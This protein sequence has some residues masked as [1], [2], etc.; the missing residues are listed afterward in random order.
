MDSLRKVKTTRDG[1]KDGGK[2]SKDVNPLYRKKK[3]NLQSNGALPAYQG[4]WAG[5][6]SDCV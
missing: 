3:T 2:F 6:A 5:A 4:A 1:K